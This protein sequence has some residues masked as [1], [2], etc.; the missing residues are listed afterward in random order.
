MHFLFDGLSSRKL[1]EEILGLDSG[2]SRGYQSWAVLRHYGLG[3]DFKGIFKGMTPS[4]VVSQLPDDPQY[5]LIYDIVSGTIEE[6]GLEPNEWVKGFTKERLVKTRVNQDRFRR[7][8][9]RRPTA[10]W[11]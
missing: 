8:I 4:E 1:D 5:D 9:P 10:G 7:S 2:K 3:N 6:I 11:I